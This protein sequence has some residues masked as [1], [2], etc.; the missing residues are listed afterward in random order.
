MSS[1]LNTNITA[2]IHYVH[3]AQETAMFSRMQILSQTDPFT[4]APANA[5]TQIGLL[6]LQYSVRYAVVK[7]E[8]VCS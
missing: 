6:L 3:F 2:F 5:S 1:R 7:N 4:L 8:R